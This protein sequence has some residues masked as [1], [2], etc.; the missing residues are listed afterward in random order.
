MFR[1]VKKEVLSPKITLLEIEAPYIARKAQ[2]GQFI[3]FRIDEKGERC[4]LTIGGYD[5]EKGTI[6]IIFQRAGLTNAQG[7]YHCRQQKDA[8]FQSELTSAP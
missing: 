5:R 2:P 3:I 6:T 7:A 8:Q 4:P 1:I